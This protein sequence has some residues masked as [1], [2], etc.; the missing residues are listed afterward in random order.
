MSEKNQPVPLS[1]IDGH[2]HD[3]VAGDSEVTKHYFM[4]GGTP[5]I[6]PVDPDDVLWFGKI[7][8]EKGVDVHAQISSALETA[9]DMAI[10]VHATK[11]MADQLPEGVHV[12]TD[13][14]TTFDIGLAAAVISLIRV[15]RQATSRD[16]KLLDWAWRVIA[17]GAPLAIPQRRTSDRDHVWE[18]LNAAVY[19]QFATDVQLNDA[20]AGVDL[21][22]TFRGAQWG[23][24]CK[25][26]YAAKAD[27]RIDR[28]VD[29]VK[30]LES[31]PAVAKGIVAVNITDC[32]DHAPF[33][34]S[35]TGD[36]SIFPSTE[37]ATKALAAAVKKVALETSTASL[38]RRV[39]AD[40]RGSRRDKC[41]AVVYLGQSV[42]LAGGRVN[43]FT[44]QF[45]V[46]RIPSEVLDRT[47]A[48]R[49]HLGWRQ[50]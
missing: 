13:V 41:R 37:G 22:G 43:V 3:A 9:R 39:V 47:F 46:L 7:L 17:G 45:T 6:L 28:I 1:P 33:Q 2:P 20:G 38:R 18:V 50:L 36:R 29:G 40:K 48:N 5:A 16:S 14:P 24:E 34:H 21:K 15:F 23:V 19:S 31:D 27:R 49:Y 11:L 26:L 44:S 30:Q 42:A 12:Q 25:V 8:K 32:I 4:L 35:L 10:I